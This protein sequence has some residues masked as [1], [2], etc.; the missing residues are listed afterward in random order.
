MKLDGVF[1]GKLINAQDLP[2]REVQHGPLS[3]PKIEDP[4]D[5]VI[6]STLGKFPYE[7]NGV[8]QIDPSKIEFLGS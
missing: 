5:R 7:A 4:I 3:I 1:S 8:V 6:N 2:K